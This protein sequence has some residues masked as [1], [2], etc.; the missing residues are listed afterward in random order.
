MA[1]IKELVKTVKIHN[2]S[3]IHH[4]VMAEDGDTLF[5]PPGSHDVHEKFGWSPPAGVKL[6]RGP[7]HSIT[8]D[9]PAP[10]TTT[11]T[12]DE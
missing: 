7:V 4:T 9:S 12:T 2:D 11:T 1:N 10:T 8:S 3:R 6:V 5:L